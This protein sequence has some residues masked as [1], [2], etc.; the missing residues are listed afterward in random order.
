M[1]LGLGTDLRASET[2]VLSGEDFFEGTISSLTFSPDNRILAVGCHNDIILFDVQNRKKLP[3]AWK[4]LVGNFDLA[5]SPDG[6]LLAASNG[7]TTH[8]LDVATGKEKLAFKT[9]E[10]TE[11]KG[12]AFSADGKLLG[13]SG[14][15][16]AARL[17]DVTS[18]EEVASLEG[19]RDVVALAFDKKGK[20]LATAAREGEV[21]IIW[22]VGKRKE[23]KT[24]KG[25]PP[26]WLSTM[27]Y[28][29]DGK[30]VVTV[31][32]GEWRIVVWDVDKAEPRLSYENE[33]KGVQMIRSVNQLAL[34]A[35]GNMLFF[36]SAGGFV[37]W[38]RDLQAGA[39]IETIED[40]EIAETGRYLVALSADDSL[41]AVGV[42]KT[43]KIGNVPEK[44]KK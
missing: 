39:Q 42:G 21:I 31:G 3:T 22:D 11:G 36:M 20:T 34:S 12:M 15:T 32:H 13:L 6:K 33:R 10:Q 28:S 2:L 1:L 25:A 5:F 37:R 43:V 38:I 30:T 35:D 23:I 16:R 24:L 7:H 27:A 4:G 14:K 41:I 44:K 17:I 29:A 8:I 26:G 18:G 40:L 19:Q 9:S